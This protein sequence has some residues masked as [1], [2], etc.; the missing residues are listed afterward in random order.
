MIALKFAQSEPPDPPQAGSPM[1]R[2]ATD[3]VAVSWAEQ[4]PP[5]AKTLK[6]VLAVKLLVG[7]LMLP[8]VPATGDPTA[9]LPALFLSW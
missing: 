5:V 9:K 8:P 7:R 4:L 3:A 2:I 1:G 6:V